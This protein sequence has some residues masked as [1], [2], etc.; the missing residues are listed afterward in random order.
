MSQPLESLSSK[1]YPGRLIILGRDPSGENEVAIYAITGRS[2]SSQAR[3]LEREGDTIWAKP[4]DQ[5]LINQ[6]NRNLL[7]YPAI[8]LS[9]GIAVSN[10]QQTAD[11]K[12]FLGQSQNPAEVLTSA[13][14]RWD[15]ELDSPNFTPRISGCIISQRKAALGI[16]RRAA[17]G[18]SER[19]VFE[20]RLRAS[21]GKM[22][23]TY[24]GEDK[25]PLPSFRGGPLDVRI[26]KNNPRDMAEAVFKALEPKPDKKEYRVSVACVFSENLS[27]DEYEI[28]IINKHERTI[29]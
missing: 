3:K 6:G 28:F 4:L 25:D 15:Y 22:I 8:C 21:W 16:V 20:I 13:L 23:A 24:K 26:E 27:N 11:I 14:G 17:D 19:S 7:L 10:G 5:E 12:A 9:Q 29:K 1:E 18:S 2:P